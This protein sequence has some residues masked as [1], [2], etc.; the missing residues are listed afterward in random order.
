[1][2]LLNLFRTKTMKDESM[3]YSRL[4]ELTLELRTCQRRYLL[5]REQHCLAMEALK[6]CADQNGYC[7]DAGRIQ[8]ARRTIRDIQSVELRDM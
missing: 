4:N 5:L 1:M 3:L 6:Y 7:T 2:T 8:H